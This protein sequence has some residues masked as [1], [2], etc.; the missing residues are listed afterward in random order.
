MFASGF[1]C[2]VAHILVWAQRVLTCCVWRRAG[3]ES[4]FIFKTRE[5]NKKNIERGIDIVENCGEKVSNKD[6]WTLPI[7]RSNWFKCWNW[8]FPIVLQCY[9]EKVVKACCPEVHFLLDW[10]WPAW[11]LGN[12]L[13]LLVHFHIFCSWIVIWGKSYGG[14]LSRS[15]IFKW[16]GDGQLD[17]WGMS[18]VY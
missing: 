10:G 1:G 14:L 3:E 16:T 17:I 9:E 7:V 5:E 13:C 15:P 2:W 6:S 12:E 8:T 11:Q 4:L 18:C